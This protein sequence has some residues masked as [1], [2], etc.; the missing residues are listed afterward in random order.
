MKSLSFTPER[1]G[2]RDYAHIQIGDV[3]IQDSFIREGQFFYNYGDDRDWFNI[4]VA[5]AALRVKLWYVETLEE[6]RH[7]A[8][9]VLC[10]TFLETSGKL[11]FWTSDWQITQP[12]LA[13]A[14]YFHSWVGVEFTVYCKAVEKY[15]DK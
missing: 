13:A 1:Y 3:D 9:K 4:S 7:D 2:K 14:P 12:M 11:R 10:R 6:I 15:R 8:R 5:Q